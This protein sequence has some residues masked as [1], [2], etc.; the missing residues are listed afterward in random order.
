[1]GFRQIDLVFV[2]LLIIAFLIIGPAAATPSVILPPTHITPE[3][4]AADGYFGAA[5][6]IYGNA[7]L[8]GEP[9]YD[10]DHGTA[11]IYGITD[12]VWDP[13]GSFSPDNPTDEE[14][15]FGSSVAISNNDV[16]IGEPGATY[17]TKQDAGAAYVG[18]PDVIQVHSP[19]PVKNGD[20]G[21]SVALSG[22][23]LVVGEPGN[24]TAYIYNA[25]NPDAGPVYTLYGVAGTDFGNVVAISGN[26]LAVGEPGYNF[27][28]VRI[29]TNTGSGWTQAGQ[30]TSSLEN[31]G[32]GT[33][34]ALSGNTLVVGEPDYSIGVGRVDIYTSSGSAWNLNRTLMAD[35]KTNGNE[36]GDAVAVS[37]NTIVVGEPWGKS[38][39]GIGDAYLYTYNNGWNEITNVTAPVYQGDEYFGQ[40]VGISGNTVVIGEPGGNDLTPSGESGDAYIYTIT[41]LPPQVIGISPTTGSTSGGTSVTITGNGF[42][43]A[44]DVYF[45]TTDVPAAS[46]T[47]LSDTQIVLN[48][49]A[50]SAGMVD[51]TVKT[52]AGTSATS[53]ADEFTY[54]APPVVSG[55]LPTSG[56][57]A[58]GTSITITGTGFTGATD[59][60]FGA[61]DV[62]AASFTSA[63][64]TQI[65]VNSPAGS[66][67]EVHVTVKTAVA[68]SATSTA[69]QFTYETVP[70][71]TPAITTPIFVGATSVN[72]T[73]VSGASV[74]LSISGVAQTPVTA[75]GGVWNVTGLSALTASENISVTAILSPDTISP[76]ATANILSVNGDG[77]YSTVVTSAVNAG[78]DITSVTVSSTDINY[79]SHLTITTTGLSGPPLNDPLAPGTVFVYVDITPSQ[80][81]TSPITGV[82]SFTVLQS[83]L[84]ANGLSP[85]NVVLEHYTSGTW[86]ALPATFVS[87]PDGAGEDHF[88]ATTTGF[89]P[90]AITWVATPTPTPTATSSARPHSAGTC[91]W[92]G[93]SGASGSSTGYTGPSTTQAGGS[94]TQMPTVAKPTVMPTQ[95][96]TFNQPASASITIAPLP[97]N[98]PKTGLDAVPVIGAIGLCGAMFLFR[99]N[100]N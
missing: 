92:C 8:V 9:N 50:G 82:I 85:Q 61:T 42:T 25:G 6:A 32:F 46:F 51:V 73:A 11:E 48:S 54:A 43:G 39:Y 75:T 41:G 44:T 52:P 49:P 98:T 78:A 38:G 40:S 15:Y 60:Y 14:S 96:V 86:Q 16:A 3:Y 81:T 18:F 71:P 28:T 12:G 30:V 83:W 35:T 77:T 33:S 84:T 59:V 67:G 70:T 88:T 79:L 23:T 94:P 19:N 45:G 90:F 31:T 56:S 36:F 91:Y 63:L 10:N 22:N 95:P 55:I 7:V 4:P 27:G 5:V 21:K 64:A 2:G 34:L 62:P 13:S 65:V 76:A 53:S 87:G 1:M 74:V 72:G 24:S 17:A 100:G 20:F 47:S 29:F 58:G 93:S 37:G 66:A 99:K 26:T 80:T 57:T 68:S 97:T 89:S 69:D